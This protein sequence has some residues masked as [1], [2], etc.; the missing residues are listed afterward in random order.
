MSSIEFHWSERDKEV[1][2]YGA[3][4]GPVLLDNI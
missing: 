2:L 3:G 4:S 1:V